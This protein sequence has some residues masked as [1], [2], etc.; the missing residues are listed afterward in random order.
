M[1]AL[2]YKL[3]NYLSKGL[4]RSSASFEILYSFWV[5]IPCDFVQYNIQFL[6]EVPVNTS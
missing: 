6:P 1:N 4:K 3:A 5:Q 2:S